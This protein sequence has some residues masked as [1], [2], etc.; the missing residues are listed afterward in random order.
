MLLFFIV[1]GTGE[2]HAAANDPWWDNDWPY[3]VP[4][5]VNHKGPVAVN[6]NFSQLFNNLGLNQALLDLRSIRVIPYTDGKAG[7]PVPF[8]ETYSTTVIDADSLGDVHSDHWL[9]EESITEINIDTQ[10]FTQGLGSIHLHAKITET[11]LS[12]TGFS[13]QFGDN[14]SGNWSDYELLLY[15]VYPEVNNQAVDQA[16]DLYNFELYDIP[17]CL[18]NQI[19]GPGLKINQWNAVSLSLAPF[20]SCL[21][22]DLSDLDAMRFFLKVNTPCDN[23]GYFDQGDEVDFWMDNF[24]LI[25]QDGSGKIIW[26]SDYEVEKYYIYF[27]TLDHEGHP[28]PTA[29]E[30][31]DPTP[32][33]AIGEPEAGGYFHRI[34]GVPGSQ[35]IVWTAPPTEKILPTNKP[36]I[37]SKPLEAFAAKG[38]HEP[39]QLIIN[40][41]SDQ[42]L[43]I[44][45]GNLIHEKGGS[46]IDA[47]Q[48]DI[49][50]VDYIEL[51]RISDQFGRIGSQPDPL[52]PLL[53]GESVNFKEAQNQPLWFRIKV[54]K[55]AA[56]GIYLGK[57]F[58]GEIEIPFT[59]KVWN[60]QLPETSLLGTEFGF[61]W[62]LL[63]ETYQ[64]AAC[65][66]EFRS[67]VDQ[68][69]KDL[70]IIP[71]DNTTFPDG[72]IYTL[73]SYEIQKAQDSQLQNNTK[74]WWKFSPTDTPPFANPAVIDRTG[75]DARILPWIA[76]LDRIDGLYYPQTTGWDKNPWI[77]PM[78]EYGS[79]GNDFFFYPPDE[80]LLA[81]TPC[82]PQRDRL[83]PSIRLELLREGLDDYAYLWLLNKSDAVIGVENQ[84]DILARSI[85]QS[86]NLFSRIPNSF[87][88]IRDEIALSLEPTNIDNNN[89]YYLPII[90]H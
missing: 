10:R 81:Y 43:P 62:D 1:N 75:T 2:T 13:F 27:D 88:A 86:E 14:G 3:R 33:T 17:N 41:I 47:A 66:S 90:I 25:D 26:L 38:E 31:V 7:A 73:A 30:F 16:P 51:N 40:S 12:T 60:F 56:P 34:D 54:P 24:R 5:V 84:S 22:P 77:N 65:E 69:F 70:R 50:R 53:D 6:L 63:V 35:V 68:T 8:Q 18:F 4:V 52:F 80:N 85:I 23:G 44:S 67:I 29:A 82:T 20:G 61:D 21:S 89:Y 49:F 74:V 37:E 57:I 36:P 58:I 28:T 76:W 39:I 48:I 64:A 42:T 72:D 11:S 46:I 71:I 78:D 45:V 9:A 87:Y 19:K 55:D 83:I 32:I 79:N 15:D 59:L